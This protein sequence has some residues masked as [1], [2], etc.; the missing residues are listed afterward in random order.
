M[1]IDKLCDWGERTQPTTLWIEWRAVFMSDQIQLYIDNQGEKHSP[2]I[3]FSHGLS[4]SARNWRGQISAFKSHYHLM[5]YDLRGH[6][7]SSAPLDESTYNAPTLVA[8]LIHVLDVLHAS[9]T[10]QTLNTDQ[11]LNTTQTS[12]TIRAHQPVLCGLSLGAAVSLEAALKYPEKFKGLVLASYP[13][14]KTVLKS[15]RHIAKEFAEAIRCHGLDRAGE[16]YVWGKNSQLSPEDTKFIRM[17]FLEHKDHGI[18]NHLSAFLAPLPELEERSEELQQ[19]KLPTLIIAGSKDLP[20][21]AS[22]RLLAK[23]I[24]NS[25]IAIISNAGHLVNIEDKEMFNEKLQQFLKKIGH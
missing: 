11:T 13:S 9:N 5:S 22:A 7:R 15:I 16:Q 14:S 3:I 6:A 23:Y 10:T 12:N 21:V 19:L 24:P 2:A 17:G 25:E 1:S 20:C 18:A 4:G 8:D